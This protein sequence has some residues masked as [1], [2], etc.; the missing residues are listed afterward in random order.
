MSALPYPKQATSTPTEAIQLLLDMVRGTTP[1]AL[2]PAIKA[3]LQ[4]AEYITNFFDEKAL[5]MSP[6]AELTLRNRPPPTRFINGGILLFPIRL[7][8]DV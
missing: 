5:P 4:I 6:S 3:A 2:V 7:L 1:F 8:P